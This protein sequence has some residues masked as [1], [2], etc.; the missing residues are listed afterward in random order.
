M[1]GGG[2]DPVD[3][4]F[5]RFVYLKVRTR[6]FSPDILKPGKLLKFAKESLGIKF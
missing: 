6:V 1:V 2:R 3:F 4:F 5:T